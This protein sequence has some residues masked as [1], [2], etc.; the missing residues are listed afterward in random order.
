MQASINQ[1]TFAQNS[2]VVNQYHHIGNIFAQIP[3]AS[4]EALPL[5]R[6]DQVQSANFTVEMLADE[7][8]D[9]IRKL[10]L[11]LSSAPNLPRDM[12]AVCLWLHGV[13]PIQAAHSWFTN[14]F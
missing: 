2:K 5:V 9:R 6:G 14:V 13:S 12:G 3:W 1:L 8:I 11:G 7:R 4:A 10:I